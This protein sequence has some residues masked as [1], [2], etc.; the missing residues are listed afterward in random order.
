MTKTFL[1]YFIFSILIMFSFSDNCYPAFIDS[2]LGARSMAM[3]GAYTALADDADGGLVNP[4]GLSM[5][6]YQQLSATTAVLH[7]GLDDDSMIT[8]NIVGYAYK[9]SIGSLGMAWK[10]FGAGDLY[11]E[12]ILAISYARSGS[13][14][15]TKGDKGRRKNISYGGNIKLLNW[16]SAPTVDSGGRTIE[17]L[18]GWTGINFDLGFIIFPSANTPVAVSFQNIRKSHINSDSSKIEEK[19]PL[20]TRMGVAAIDNN[21]TWVIDLILKQGQIDL[22]LGL[23]RKSHDG[24]FLIRTGIALE[25]LAWG[26][27]FTV[28]AG[29]KLGEKTRLDYAFMYPMNTIL[30]TYGSHRVSIV[31]N[32]GDNK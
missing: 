1:I 7:A 13:L 16:D 18:P 6:E 11:Y 17:D 2:Y 32:F 27:N 10:R 25:N 29:Y 20:T 28:G 31:Y 3:G 15:F 8:Q 24:N 22:K 4:A 23:E 21:T 19:L 14:Y 9:S 26:M 12:N 30:E 5:I